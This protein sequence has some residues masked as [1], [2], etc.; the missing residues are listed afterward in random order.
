MTCAQALHFVHKD[1]RPFSAEEIDT[2]LT[3]TAYERVEAAE[4]TLSSPEVSQICSPGMPWAFRLASVTALQLG[5][6]QEVIKR[7]T[8][9]EDIKVSP[10]TTIQ[11]PEQ[12]EAPQDG[13]ALRIWQTRTVVPWVPSDG[14]DGE[15]LIQE[16]YNDLLVA[17]TVIAATREE[18]IASTADHIKSSGLHVAVQERFLEVLETK[19][20]AMPDV[21][22]FQQLLMGRPRDP[23][24]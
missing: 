17:I 19:M 15:R 9:P 24:S 11:S 12:L 6:V 3:A 4:A 8:A 10:D 2:V 16:G 14:V 18:A 22:L 13:N 5:E 21:F 20:Q 7:R 23:E 1:G